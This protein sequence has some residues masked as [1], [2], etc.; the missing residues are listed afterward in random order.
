[1]IIFKKKLP[2]QKYS[3]YLDSV[4][5]GYS[6]IEGMIQYDKEG[7]RFSTYIPIERYTVEE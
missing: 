3:V 6:E 7:N 5:I 2:D 4:L 1:M